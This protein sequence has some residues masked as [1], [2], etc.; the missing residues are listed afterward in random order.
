M[1]ISHYCGFPGF[2]VNILYGAL[3]LFPESFNELVV[4]GRQ[5]L[6]FKLLFRNFLKPGKDFFK[7]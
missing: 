6:V 2:L 5:F 1:D 7:V 3:K 4:F